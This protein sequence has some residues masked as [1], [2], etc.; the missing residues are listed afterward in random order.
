MANN[1]DTANTKSS[2]NL[3]QFLN[4]LPLDKRKQAATLLYRVRKNLHD[5]I[6]TKGPV[7][8]YLKELA[9]LRSIF[10]PLPL[11]VRQNTKPVLI[12]ALEQN[13]NAS[14]FLFALCSKCL[15]LLELTAI[16]NADRIDLEAEDVRRTVHHLNRT[17]IPQLSTKV[18]ALR[19]NM[20]RLEAWSL[21]ILIFTYQACIEC[22]SSQIDMSEDD[23]QLT[24]RLD[25]DP[26]VIKHTCMPV[27]L[28]KFLQSQSKRRPYPI[29]PAPFKLFDLL[30]SCSVST[31][32][33]LM[34]KAQAVPPYDPTVCPLEMFEPSPS[35]RPC[36]TDPASQKPSQPLSIFIPDMSAEE[37]ETTLMT[38]SS[39]RVLLVLHELIR[40]SSKPIKSSSDTVP[41]WVVAL[42]CT[43]H[44]LIKLQ[45]KSDKKVAQ[46]D[47]ISAPL[48][49]Y[50]EAHGLLLR[51]WY[52]ASEQRTLLTGLPQSYLWLMALVHPHYERMSESGFLNSVV[53]LSRFLT[54]YQSLFR[55]NILASPHWYLQAIADVV[56]A[57]IDRLENATTQN[58][59][60]LE[61]T[62]CACLVAIGRPYSALGADESDARPE[63]SRVIKMPLETILARMACCRT[64]RSETGASHARSGH[65]MNG[66]VRPVLG[67][68]VREILNNYLL[69]PMIKTMDPW[70]LGQTM[71]GLRPATAKLLLKQ[72]VGEIQTTDN[73][74]EGARVAER[75]KEVKKPVA[76]GGLHVAEKL[77]VKR[78]RR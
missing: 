60:T 41:V 2:E 73:R 17:I 74:W 9:G 48:T 22:L 50:E 27:V 47:S 29:P 16:R 45:H 20:P 71:V 61:D 57:V 12:E 77:A 78:K 72:L 46:E 68:R 10:A 31:N 67:R 5:V 26:N 33:R 52:R 66:P 54:A 58:L 75:L 64:G 25:Y 38:S 28:S 8:S 59:D 36:V 30:F 49:T 53:W 18:L 37:L 3:K 14:P 6:P 40:F 1:K 42:K 62:M 63:L 69:L 76:V 34:T 4:T 19:T 44:I 24:V 65:V 35:K 15:C 51:L 13:L 21:G 32:Y 43:P 23:G 39:K 56:V 55:S 11:S 70:A 7:D